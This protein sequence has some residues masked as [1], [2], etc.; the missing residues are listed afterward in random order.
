MDADN[1]EPQQDSQAEGERTQPPRTERPPPIV[2][3]AVTNLIQLQKHTQRI[4]KGTFEF[5]STRNRTNVVTREVAD[6]TAIKTFFDNSK[7]SYYT[8]FPKSEKP[9]TA[10][11]RQLAIHTPGE[12][13]SNGLED[14]GFNVVNVKHMTTTR[15]SPED[16]PRSEF[17]PLFLVTLPR[18]TKSTDI[19]N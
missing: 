11:I 10:V 8:F 6:F 7:L 2:L 16:G 18:T 5:R 9:M 13:I 4:V 17:L 15:K 19:L 12:D 1:E 14:M 3:A